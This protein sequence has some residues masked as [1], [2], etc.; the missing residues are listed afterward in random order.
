MTTGGLL[1]LR[2]RLLGPFDITCDGR[3][4]RLQLMQI[5]II[6]ALWCAHGPVERDNLIRRVWPSH[7]ADKWPTL[8]RHLSY[9]RAALEKAGGSYGM[10]ISEPAGL[11]RMFQITENIS[12]DVHE[13]RQLADDGAAALRDGR[14]DEASTLQR[15]ALKLWNPD[16]GTGPAPLS[17]VARHGFADEYIAELRAEYKS[18]ALDSAKADISTGWHERSVTQLR[19]LDRW[20]P[21]QADT[22]ELLAIAL[23]RCGSIHEASQT[24]QTLI[25]AA[26]D[27]AIGLPRLRQLQEQ[28]L[29]ETLPRRG[30]LPDEF[31]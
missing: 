7:A 6:A 10:L 23:Y 15:K 3:R 31:I 25:S 29:N 17:C 27:I 16:S 11:G 28:I 30:P 20:Y 9:L 24:L 8:R 19:K 2:A 12:S 1:V 18:S 14:Y 4:V 26:N 5:V 21:G 22:G 13:F